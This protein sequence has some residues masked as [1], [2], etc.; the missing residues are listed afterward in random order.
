MI[1]HEQP[2]TTTWCNATKARGEAPA[3]TSAM[4]LR[5]WGKGIYKYLQGKTGDEFPSQPD[6]DDDD[7]DMDE[8]KLD[9]KPVPVMNLVPVSSASSS[10]AAASSSS[11]GDGGSGTADSPVCLD[12]D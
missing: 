2:G 5:R 9:S 4:L 6:D 8:K 12:D 7:D 10:A 1:K 11:G 3:E